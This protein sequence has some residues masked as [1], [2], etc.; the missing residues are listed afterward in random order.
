LTWPVR[1]WELHGSFLA[2]QAPLKGAVLLIA[3]SGPTDR[4]WESLML[5]GPNGS[6]RL[7]AEFF[8]AKGFASLRY[9]KLGSGQTGVPE[10]YLE[11]GFTFGAVDYIS[12]L[13]GALSAL[14]GQIPEGT[15]LFVAGHSEGGLWALEIN[16]LLPDVFQGVILLATAGRS[17]C[18]LVVEQIEAQLKDYQMDV[19]QRDSELQN[20]QTSLQ[21]VSRGEPLIDETLPTLPALRGIVDAYS[22]PRAAELTR[23]LCA[24]DPTTLL[25]EDGKSVLILQGGYDQQV[26]ADA[27]AKRL[28][29]A[30]PGSSLTIA[31]KA[32]HVL[33]RLELDGQPLNILHTLKYNQAERQLDPLLTDALYAWLLQ[34]TETSPAESAH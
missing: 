19:S 6:G 1:D 16:R 17:Q 8:S 5:P 20:L 7:I 31:P 3:G 2:N 34:Q 25:P 15:P 22:N 29:L 24:T 18:S 27:D 11:P 28:H 9:D 4:N 21:H 12:G 32:D 33:K 10:S 14:Q 13:K 30:A 23:W 26:D